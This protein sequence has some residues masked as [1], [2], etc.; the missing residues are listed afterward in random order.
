[1]VVIVGR[2]NV[3]KSTLFNRMVGTRAAIVENIP[4]VTRDR[5]YMETEWEGKAFIAV[6][7]GGFYHKPEEDIFKQIREQAL[8]AIEEADVIIHL[9][10]AKEGLTHTDIE[11]SKMLRASGKKVLWVVN[12]VD[13]PKKETLLYDFF[14]LGTDELIPVSAE[15]GYGFG[16]MMDKIALLLP[17]NIKETVSY[18]K[19]AVI[20]KPN[21]GKS[22]LVNSLLGKNR[23]IV[24]SSAGT[25][26]DSVDS[27]CKYYK[28]KY[29]I[30]DTAGIRK[31]NKLSFSVEKFSVINAMKSIERC[32]VALLLIDSTKGITEQDQTIA[33]LTEYYGK[34]VIILLNK[35]DIVP[36]PEIAYKKIVSEIKY[37]LWFLDYA[38]VITTSG[39]DKRNIT[40]IFPLID[41]IIEA[42]KKRITTGELN[43]IM[44]DIIAN[45]PMPSYKGRAIKILY[46]TQIKTEPPSFAVFSNHPEAIKKQYLKYIERCLRS[47]FSFAGTPIRIYNKKKA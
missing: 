7:T 13:T 47:E 25:T 21:V 24:S 29:L 39:L 14:R 40:K 28:N 33:G 41:E 18:P 32:D 16:D 36:E 20:G 4:N 8:L 30:I 38:P 10:D 27:I 19:I 22:T 37:K 46:M 42:R 26:R 3:G 35:W 23:M 2:A 17:K 12:K 44:R 34:G 15:N 43:R 11:L 5:N 31:K 6:D 45:K 1:M 9:L